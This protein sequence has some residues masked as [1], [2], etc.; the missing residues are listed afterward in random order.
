MARFDDVD[1][2]LAVADAGSFRAAATRLEVTRSTVSRAVAR[3]EAHLGT[4][5]FLRDTAAV[6]ITEAGAAYRRGARRAA[7]AL[8]R[9]EQDARDLVGGLTGTVRLSAPPAFGPGSLVPA[10]AAFLDA[11][12]GIQV[13][14][15]FTDRLINPILDGIDLAVRTGPRLADSD[16]KSRK[17]G[18]L[19]LLAVASP[20]LAASL[21]EEGPLPAVAMR[22]PDGEVMHYPGAPRLLQSRLVVDDYLAARDAAVSG[23]GVAVLSDLLV[24]DEIARGALVPVLPQWTLP[25]GKVWAV[26]A[27]RGRLPARTRSLLDALIAWGATIGVSPASP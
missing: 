16:L 15:V 22:R 2:F 23:V 20:A 5:L 1:V 21:P 26:Y 11:H 6:R 18:D 14:C 8:T 10:V 19:R 24:A 13:D 7:L 3:L 17:L 25:T 9:A 4:A 27:A 12:P